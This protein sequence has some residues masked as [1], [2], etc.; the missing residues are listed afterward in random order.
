MPELYADDDGMTRFPLV[1][2][3]ICFSLHDSFGNV[4][5]MDVGD[6]DGSSPDCTSF[7]GNP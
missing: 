5:P 7:N 4:K 3:T 1:D 2:G 6:M